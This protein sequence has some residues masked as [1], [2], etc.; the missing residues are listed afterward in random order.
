LPRRTVR[1]SHLGAVRVAG[2]KVDDALHRP[3]RGRL[4]GVHPGGDDDS[5]LPAYLVIVRRCGDRQIVDTVAGQAAT[6]QAQLGEARLRRVGRDLA[7]ILLACSSRAIRDED[8]E[9]R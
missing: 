1:P 5:P 7:E 6:Q 4:A 2:E 9:I 3:A 8:E